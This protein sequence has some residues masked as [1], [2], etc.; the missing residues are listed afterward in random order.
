MK[1]RAPRDA[2]YFSS[3]L[4]SRV[5]GVDEVGRGPLAGPV[6]AAAV[7]LQPDRPIRGLR[8]SKELSAQMRE[9]LAERIRSR[10]IA[11]AVAS[12]SVAE[13]DTLNI[14]HASMLA[15]QRAIAQLPN[16]CDFALIDGKARPRLDVPCEPIVSGDAKVACIAAASILAKVARDAVMRALHLEYPHYGFDQHMGYATPLHLLALRA[17]GPSPEHRR[18]FAPVRAALVLPLF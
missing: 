2:K 10:A 3:C 17:H 5:A 16:G 8:D 6:F 11:F 13:I 18:S 15:M 14:F 4:A 1:S 12:A 7:I 9:R